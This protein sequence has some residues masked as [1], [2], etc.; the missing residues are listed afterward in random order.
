MQPD[1]LLSS[2]VMKH[3]PTMPFMGANTPV[4]EAL[5]MLGFSGD[6]NVYS[7][8]A[9]NSMSRVDPK[10]ESAALIGGGIVAGAAIA[11]IV[12]MKVCMEN[13]TGVTLKDRANGC[14]SP[15][16]NTVAKCSDYCTTLALLLQPL[17]PPDHSFLQHLFASRTTSSLESVLSS[18][19]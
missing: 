5:A 8:A 1:G 7:Y 19:M 6:Q 2:L 12:L 11:Y 4:N 13:G 18:V 10:G 16:A 14:D 17:L 15:D 9:S 3:A